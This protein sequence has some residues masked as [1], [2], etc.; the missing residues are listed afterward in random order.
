MKNTILDSAGL[1][2]V[3]A[4]A[5]EVEGP[6]AGGRVGEAAGVRCWGQGRGGGRSR[7]T[8]GS[9]SSHP[10]WPPHCQ[11]SRCPSVPG[12]G[13]SPTICIMHID[14]LK[15]DIQPYLQSDPVVLGEL[16]ALEAAQLALTAEVEVLVQVVPPLLPA[17]RR[18]HHVHVADRQLG[19]S[20][21]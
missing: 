7:N 21:H 19:P 6:G 5:G 4:G 16:V 18:R 12:T 14:V 15:E 2:G 10:G 8:P 1:P 3:E 13:I 17:G 20:L 9:S 11:G